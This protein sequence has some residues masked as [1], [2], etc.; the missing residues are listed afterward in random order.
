MPRALRPARMFCTF[1]MPLF[2]LQFCAG[3]EIRE[4]LF[5]P[6]QRLDPLIL[7]IISEIFEERM[8]AILRKLESF[9]TRNTLPDPTQTN[10][11]IGVARQWIF[12]QFKSYCPRLELQFD[13][14]EEHS[15]R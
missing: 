7:K 12:D 6:P 14:H 15:H 5:E 9:E 1:C 8:T 13:T 10:R 3:G 4:E 2:I 11:G